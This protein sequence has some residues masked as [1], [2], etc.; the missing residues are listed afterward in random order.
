[1]FRKQVLYCLNHTSGPLCSGYFGVSQT[2]CSDWPQTEILLVSASQ[3]ARITGMS[4]WHLAIIF[5]YLFPIS[6]M[7]IC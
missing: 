4:H 7:K 3:V 6:T 5:H 1:M 2:I